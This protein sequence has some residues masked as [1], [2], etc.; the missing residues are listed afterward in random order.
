MKGALST[1]KATERIFDRSDPDH[2]R[3]IRV[4]IAVFRRSDLPCNKTA[5]GNHKTGPVQ[6]F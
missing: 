2:R 5:A 1:G 3:G 6:S 4:G